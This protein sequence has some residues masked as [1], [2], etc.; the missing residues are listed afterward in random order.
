M[1]I[2]QDKRRARW[3]RNKQAERARR[4]PY[5]RIL[6]NEFRDRVLDERDLRVDDALRA[7]TVIR[8]GH[9]FYEPRTYERAIRFAADVWAA[10]TWL[11]EEWGSKGAMPRRVRTWLEEHGA[12]HGYSEKS[13]PKMLRKARGRIEQLERPQ[14][15]N[16][17]RP[18][19]SPFNPMETSD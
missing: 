11:R 12:P 19:W 2:D 5:P 6:P 18:I 1:A 16:R 3:Q 7:D 8:I 10:D 17:D 13:L 4:S 14:P 15:W 9:A